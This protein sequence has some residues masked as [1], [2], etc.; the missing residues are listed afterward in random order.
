L[1]SC[2]YTF[3]IH[4]GLIPNENGENDYFRIPYV[5]FL[6][7]N[8][9]IITDTRG[10]VVYKKQDYDNK[11]SG[12]DMQG[13]PLPEGEYRYLLKVGQDYRYQRSGTILIN[14]VK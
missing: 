10:V 6:K 13:N 14:Y 3:P 1:D 7:P 12:T 5:P 11:W 9:L 4:G 2:F 8:Q